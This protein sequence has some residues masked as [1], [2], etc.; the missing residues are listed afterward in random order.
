M[1]VIRRIRINLGDLVKNLMKVV[2]PKGV[3]PPGFD[4]HS[5]LTIERFDQ[6]D[7]AYR[8]GTADKRVI[9]ES[10]SHDP[11]LRAVSEYTANDGEIQIDVGAHIGTFSLFAS[12]KSRHCTVHA[13]EASLDTY[14][15]LRIN[16][17]LNPNSNIVAH[18]LALADSNG[19]TTL[20]H[21]SGNWG[22]SIVSKRSKISE[23]TQ[24]LTLESFMATHNIPRCQFI[25]FNCEG[26]EFPILLSTP[27]AVLERLEVILVLYHCDLWKQNDESDLVSH[28]EGSGMTTRLV[29]QSKTR[30]WIIGV[31]RL[32]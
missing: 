11:Y 14:N 8:I 3:I 23:T 29:R 10:F 32:G 6:F 16:A 18:H 27:P 13:I 12:S 4:R 26:A 7:V 28:L 5:G 1:S 9:D 2:L 21:E 30:G 20:F 25:K 19:S 15:V 22:H 24:A 31:S 17:A